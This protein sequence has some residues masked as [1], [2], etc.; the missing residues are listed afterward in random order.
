MRIPPRSIVTACVLP[1]ALLAAGCAGTGVKEDRVGEAVFLQAATERGPEPFTESGAGSEPKT[2]ASGPA[3]HTDSP[4]A[5]GTVTTGPAPDRAGAT[6]PPTFAPDSSAPPPFTPAPSAVPTGG[7]A[8]AP[9]PSA[10]TLSGATPGLYRGTPH[11]AGCAVERQIGSLTADRGKA[12]AFAHAVGV[13]VSTLPGYL[14][15]LTPVALRRDTRVTSH[16]YRDRRAVGYQAV[17]QAGTAVLVDDRGVPRV[18]CACGN[19]LK[20]PS[21]AHDGVDARGAA[22]PG[23]RPSQVIAVTPARRA[24]TSITIVDVDA[25]VWIERRTGQDVGRDR[26]VAPPP[27]VPVSPTG[28]DPDRDDPGA[29]APGGP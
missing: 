3:P 15:G 22:W 19:P 13:P 29:P 14:R 4:A 10:H 27:P 25:R 23:Y 9:L 20:A 12:G 28:P 8:L 5:A 21:A 7:R 26:I 2:T 6:M 11:V 24:V 17:L 1:V 18:R 16:G